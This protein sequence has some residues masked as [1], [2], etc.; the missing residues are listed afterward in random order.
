VPD[1]TW[2][3]IAGIAGEEGRT[4]TAVVIEALTRHLAWHKRQARRSDG[5]DGG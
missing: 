5:Q 1:K 3:A 4:V 2:D